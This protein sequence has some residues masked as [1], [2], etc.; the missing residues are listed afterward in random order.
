MFKSKLLALISGINIVFLCFMVYPAVGL[1]NSSADEQAFSFTSYNVSFLKLPTLFSEDYWN[2]SISEPSIDIQNFLDTLETE[3]I[4][5]QEFF[6]DYN[7]DDY[8]FIKSFEEKGYSYFF[9]NN[10]RHANGVKKGLITLTKFP[11]IDSGRIFLSKNRYNGMSYVDILLKSDTVRIINVHL[12]SMQIFFSGSNYYNSLKYAVL[13][14]IQ[15]VEQRHDQIEILNAF[16]DKTPHKVIV[17]GD[18][19]ELPFSY[20]L[21]KMHET[22]H[23]AFSTTEWGLGNT[24]VNSRIPLRI[25][26]QFYSFGIKA[27]D[28]EILKNIIG[29]DHYP[30]IVHYSLGY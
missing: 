4:C 23:S 7:N 11:I 16:I 26:Q 13:R 29:S 27:L 14:W 30:I 9:L 17:A 6:N 22:L 10:P 5:F 2:H 8:N 24:I 21:S 3:V 25:D 19:N 12:Q 15:T 18:F 28:H 1:N 20:N